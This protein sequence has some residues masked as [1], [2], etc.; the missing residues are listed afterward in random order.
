MLRVGGMLCLGWQSTYIA[1]KLDDGTSPDMIRRLRRYGRLGELT[2]R[3][4][5][6]GGTHSRLPLTQRQAK[7]LAKLAA[8]RGLT[9]EEWLRQVAVAAIHD[10]L[11]EAVVDAAD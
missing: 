7:R 11:F 9:P 2:G 10:D 4:A 5:T 6:R 8:A 3:P 1:D